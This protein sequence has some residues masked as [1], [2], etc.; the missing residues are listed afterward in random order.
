MNSNVVQQVSEDEAREVK[1]LRERIRRQK[2]GTRPAAITVEQVVGQFA[3]RKGVPVSEVSVTYT[4][5]RDE[6]LAALPT[7]LREQV[8]RRVLTLEKACAWQR[9]LTAFDNDDEALRAALWTILT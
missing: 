6:Q 2:G 1:R 3:E 5:T 7:E 4:G 9:L 8:R